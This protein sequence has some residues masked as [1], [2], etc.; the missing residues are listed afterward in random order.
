MLV[1]CSSK[2]DEGGYPSI[3]GVWNVVANGRRYQMEITKEESRLSGYI[4][5]VA[6]EETFELMRSSA[7]YS[8]QVTINFMRFDELFELLG[9]VKFNFQTIEGKGRIVNSEDIKFNWSASR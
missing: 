1:S 4:Y 9:T 8:D 6:A 3:N 5:D 2:D 7:M